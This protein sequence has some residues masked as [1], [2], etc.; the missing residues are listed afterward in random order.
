M[1]LSHCAECGCWL[2]PAESCLHIA[3]ARTMRWPADF[4]GAHH[5]ASD[6][7]KWKALANP[8]PAAS[9]FRVAGA[10][11]AGSLPHSGTGLGRCTDNLLHAAPCA[12]KGH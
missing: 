5:S 1:T 2:G 4:D 3:P 8:L 7:A 12:P 9:T 10:P 11:E 6:L